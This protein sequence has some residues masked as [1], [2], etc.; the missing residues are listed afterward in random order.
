MEGLTRTEEAM[1][2]QRLQKRQVKEFMNSAAAAPFG[3]NEIEEKKK[4]T[5]SQTSQI[6]GNVVDHCFNACIDDFTSKTLSSRENG[7]ITRCVQKQMFS[8]Q[9]LSE[10]FQE[11]NAEMTAKMQQQ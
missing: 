8:Q 3:E 10:R 9:R 1:L 2:Q 6:F 4:L 11:H 7:C 5:A